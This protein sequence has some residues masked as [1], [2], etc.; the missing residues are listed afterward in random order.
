MSVKLGTTWLGE[1]NSGTFKTWE[2]VKFLK[3]NWE[4]SLVLKGIQSVGVSVTF[5]AKLVTYHSAY[6]LTC[7]TP[8]MLSQ[9]A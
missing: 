4:G 2:D 7:R 9:L 6:C 5:A 3:D 1:C 8:R